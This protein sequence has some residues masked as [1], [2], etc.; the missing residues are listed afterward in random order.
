MTK[1][2]KITNTPKRKRYNRQD[3][4][5]NA[6]KWIEQYNGKNIVKGYSNYFGVN[7][8]CAITELEMIG[9]KVKSS[10]KEQVIQ[11][12][13]AKQNDKES[14]KSKN[15]WEQDEEDESLYYIAGY[16][17]N[18]VPYGLSMEEIEKN[19]VDVLRETKKRSHYIHDENLP[20]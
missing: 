3:R 10:Y 6:K 17:S 18:G 1:G 12:L 4:I 19:H 20:F 16:T 8:H 13:T 11:S 9:I 15:E 2:K 7:L 5:Q 14:L